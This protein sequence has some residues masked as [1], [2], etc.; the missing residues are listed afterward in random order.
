MAVDANY[1]RVVFNAIK[2]ASKAVKNLDL[3]KV[4]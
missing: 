2:E 3:Q 4:V 1:A